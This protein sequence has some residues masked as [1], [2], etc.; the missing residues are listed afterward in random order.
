MIDPPFIKFLW[1][2]Q[3]SAFFLLLP[4]YFPK[5]ISKMQYR[6]EIFFRRLKKNPQ[7][8][9][10]GKKL[11]MNHLGE[12]T[13]L[14]NHGQI[15]NLSYNRYLVFKKKMYSRSTGINKLLV[16]TE[17]R[18][19]YIASSLIMVRLPLLLRS[20]LSLRFFFWRSK[21]CRTTRNSL[22]NPLTAS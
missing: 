10:E 5:W 21:R 4:Y 11:C 1:L 12:V 7:I 15:M 6:G 19:S 22:G 8:S 18:F 13:K 14:M 20:Q 2:I 3:V 9:N 16:S 17:Q